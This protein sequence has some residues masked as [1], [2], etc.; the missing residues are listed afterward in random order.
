MYGYLIKINKDIYLKALE[1]DFKFFDS[2][3][4]YAN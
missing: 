4:F 2:P 3:E 1:T